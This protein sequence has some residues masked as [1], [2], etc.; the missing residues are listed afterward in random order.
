M[1]SHRDI[2]LAVFA[3]SVIGWVMVFFS[4]GGWCMVGVGGV[5][6]LEREVCMLE[7]LFGGFRLVCGEFVWRRR[8]MGSPSARLLLTLYKPRAK[9]RR[10]CFCG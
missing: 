7:H 5:N 4:L 1:E 8:C 3:S 6:V 9:N 10:K 2:G